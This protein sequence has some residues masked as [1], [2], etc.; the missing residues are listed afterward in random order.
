MIKAINGIIKGASLSI[1]TSQLQVHYNFAN[2]SSYS[3][4]GAN[5]TN[6]TGGIY[7]G[8]YNGTLQGTYSFSSTNGGYMTLTNTQAAYLDVSQ[9]SLG[10]K[11]NWSLVMW[12]R[13]QDR[14][15][16]GRV[17]VSGGN[18]GKCVDIYFNANNQLVFWVKGSTTAT[19]VSNTINLDTW[20][21]IAYTYN[22]Y[23]STNLYINNTLVTTGSN[24]GAMLYGAYDYTNVGGQS[25]S[26][27]QRMWL[28]QMA[29]YG[30]TLNNTSITQFWDVTKTRFGY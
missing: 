30:S 12:V 5:V 20:Y 15:D 24:V 17:F 27:S 29:I 19:I 16:T 11:Y 25:W 21:C 10:A 8:Y 7:S 23:G 3:G 18:A 1:P 2:S 28:G 22:A 26:F 6:I 14:S 4:T 9:Y 13:F